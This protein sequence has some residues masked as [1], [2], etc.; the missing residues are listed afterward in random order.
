[1]NKGSR[2]CKAGHSIPQAV[3]GKEETKQRK[4][5]SLPRVQYWK[6][7]K[8]TRKKKNVKGRR[9]KEKS[10][11]LNYRNNYNMT[12]RLRREE[13]VKKKR[14]KGGLNHLFVGSGDE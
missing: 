8:K 4:N 6:P 14:C 9:Q 10:G 5:Q 1:M 3:G 13:G 7:T 11:K 12:S 2:S